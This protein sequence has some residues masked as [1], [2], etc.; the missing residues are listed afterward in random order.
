[1]KL[2]KTPCKVIPVNQDITCCIE[3]KIN[4]TYYILRVC[5]TLH[6][7]KWH[8]RAPRYKQERCHTIHTRQ[9]AMSYTQNCCVVFALAACSVISHN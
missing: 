7:R 6:V 8:Q 4:D 3:G 5:F 9:F 2:V 1:M